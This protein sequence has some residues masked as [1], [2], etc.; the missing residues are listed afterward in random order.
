M[1]NQPSNRDNDTLLP[2]Q[3]KELF[4]CNSAANHCHAALALAD[5]LETSG[6]IKYDVRKS[7]LS[8]RIMITPRTD[9]RCEEQ[10][11]SIDLAGQIETRI[12]RQSIYTLKAL[13]AERATPDAAK[14]ISGCIVIDTAV[15]LLAGRVA[16]RAITMFAGVESHG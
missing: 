11:A 4:D 16:E 9:G 1:Q 8:S 12:S 7:N 3:K 14:L 10:L 15:S 2:R 13:I 5:W 6:L